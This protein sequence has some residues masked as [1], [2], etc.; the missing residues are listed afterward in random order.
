MGNGRGLVDFRHHDLTISYYKGGRRVMQV[1]DLGDQ[2]FSLAGVPLLKQMGWQERAISRPLLALQFPLDVLASDAQAVRVGPA[3]VAGVATTEYKV[4]V[5][6]T[7]LGR[8]RAAPHWIYVWVDGR[9]RL[10]RAV[11]TVVETSVSGHAGALKVT[12]SVTFDDFGVPVTLDDFGVPAAMVA[13]R[14]CSPACLAWKTS[15]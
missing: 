6:A 13:P 8:L 2:E 14:S 4:H 11:Q 9:G 12:N 15:F 7:E 3:H 10:R 1:I 5:P